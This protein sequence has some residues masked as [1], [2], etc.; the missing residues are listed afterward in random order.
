VTGLTAR[1]SGE[2]ADAMREIQRPST[3][4]RLA[5]QVAILRRM[6]APERIA[7]RY[8]VDLP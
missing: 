7:S 2:L 6:L 1:D 8:L 5:D 4:A 3:Y